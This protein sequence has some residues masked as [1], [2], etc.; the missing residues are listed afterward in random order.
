MQ[1]KFFAISLDKTARICSIVERSNSEHTRNRRFAGFGFSCGRPFKRRRSRRGKGRRM[2]TEDL[3]TLKILE[4]VDQEE[5]PSQRDLAR[6]LDI[7]LGLVNSFIKRLVKKGYFKAKTIP[8]NRVKYILTPQGAAEK[9]RLT[10][11]YIRHSFG[12][13]REMR[14]RMKNRY[15]ELEAQ[16]VRNL[17]FCGVSELA[18]IAAL[19]LHESRMTLV[20]LYDPEPR[21]ETLLDH[22]VKPLSQ[23]SENSFDRVFVTA[24]TDPAR[25]VEGLLEAGVA[26]EKIITLEEDAAANTLRWREA[27]RRIRHGDAKN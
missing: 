25:M 23:I 18:E 24:I 11:E 9:T 4:A 12:Y 6:R 22:P 10:Y 5:A 21:K 16:G 3:R 7:S 15:R 26:P 1:G 17:A 14:L 13:Y 2:E 8:K 27:A 19:M 20:G